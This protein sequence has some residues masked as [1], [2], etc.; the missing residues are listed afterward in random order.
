MDKLGIEC[1]AKL[2]ADYE[3]DR[4]TLESRDMAD[5]LQATQP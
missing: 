1:M 5:F 4:R 2:A 3:G